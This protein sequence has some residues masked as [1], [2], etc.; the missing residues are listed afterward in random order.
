M[1]TIALYCHLTSTEFGKYSLQLYIIVC[2][3]PINAP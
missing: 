2:F 3:A 1:N